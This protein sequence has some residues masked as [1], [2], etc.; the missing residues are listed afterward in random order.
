VVA[1]SLLFSVGS[2]SSAALEG[3]RIGSDRSG[4]VSIVRFTRREIEI[5]RNPELLV[6]N[7]LQAVNSYTKLFEFMILSCWYLI[8]SL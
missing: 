5:Q 1:A 4:M 3:R 8:R 2:V 7:L 6:R